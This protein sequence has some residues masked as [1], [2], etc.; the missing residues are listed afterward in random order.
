M[1]LP[2]ESCH[3]LGRCGCQFVFEAD[4]SVYPCD[5]YVVDAWRL[6]NIKDSGLVDLY[7]TPCCTEFITRSF[8]KAPECTRC[9]WLNIC[10]GGCRR[11]RQNTLTTELECNYYCEA[12]TDFLQDVYPVFHGLAEYVR[13]RNSSYSY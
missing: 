11:D 9:E 5:F 10:R 2:S 7:D 13:K 4:G 3:Q 6:G 12:F 8:K 1:G